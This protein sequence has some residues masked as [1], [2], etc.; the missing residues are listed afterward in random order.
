MLQGLGRQL[1][2]CGIDVLIL[3]NDNRHSDAIKFCQQDD[4]VILT[5]GAPFNAVSDNSTSKLKRN[6]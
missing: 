3:A 1:R 4:R 6:Y 2:S 5:S